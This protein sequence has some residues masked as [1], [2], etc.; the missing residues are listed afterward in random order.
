MTSG[1]VEIDE[2]DIL[3]KYSRR[4]KIHG[5]LNPSQE[6]EQKVPKTFALARIRTQA[7]QHKRAT[8]EYTTLW[9]IRY[10]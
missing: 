6:T 3:L 10:R 2:H 8:S 9:S 4:K 1:V 7:L 5:S